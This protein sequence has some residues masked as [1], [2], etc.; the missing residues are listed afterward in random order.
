MRCRI[1]EH[2]QNYGALFLGTG[3]NSNETGF[4][5]LYTV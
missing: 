3:L 4:I 1:I 5:V 2:V